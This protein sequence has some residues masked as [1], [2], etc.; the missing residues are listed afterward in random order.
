MSGL[1]S[2][3]WSTGASCPGICNGPA[4]VDDI[5]VDQVAAA[6]LGDVLAGLEDPRVGVG[7]AELLERDLREG[8]ALLDDDLMLNDLVLDDRVVLVDL[9]TGW[10]P[11]SPSRA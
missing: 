1:G 8:V 3:S 9:S 6:R 2:G 4:D 10:H 5:G 7:V 11:Q